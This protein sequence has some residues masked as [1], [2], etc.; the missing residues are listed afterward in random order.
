MTTSESCRKRYHRLKTQGLCP[1]CGQ[2]P[3]VAGRSRCE[4]C[5]GQH[6]QVA[7]G[8]HAKL[9]AEVFEQYG[10]RVCACCGEKKDIRFLHIDHTDGGGN[11]HRKSIGGHSGGKF[12]RWL[13]RNG[14]PRGYQVLCADCNTAKGYYGEC[15]HNEQRE[16]RLHQLAGTGAGLLY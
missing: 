12:Y 4:P 7:N 5:L 13:K 11:Q 9:K 3:F 8:A 14:F 10:G 15:P 16:E 6:R 2:R 1:V